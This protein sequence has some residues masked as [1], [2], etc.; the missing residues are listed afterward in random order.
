MSEAVAKNAAVAAIDLE[1]VIV[2]VSPK[3]VGDETKKN[4]D[5]YR[6]LTGRRNVK[7]RKSYVCG[8]AGE[9]RGE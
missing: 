3:S 8:S 9:G 5:C 1:C 2:V 4:W 7:V 6:L